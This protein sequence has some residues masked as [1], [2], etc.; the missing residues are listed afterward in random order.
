MSAMSA[1]IEDPRDEPV[2]EEEEPA[3]NER[4]TIH[5]PTYDELQFE[6]NFH[7][8]GYQRIKVHVYFVILL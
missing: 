4:V 5:R 8:L 3:I 2:T 1:P 6:A 7:P